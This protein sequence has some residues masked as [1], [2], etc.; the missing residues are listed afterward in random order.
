M[1]N[2]FEFLKLFAAALIIAALLGPHV[3]NA[4]H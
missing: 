3:W 2:G 4:V 1:K